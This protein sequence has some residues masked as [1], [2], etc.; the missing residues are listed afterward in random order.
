MRMAVL[1]FVSMFASCALFAQPVLNSEY[2]PKLGLIQTMTEIDP[3][4][5]PA[6]SVG[7]SQ[8]WDFEDIVPLDGAPATTFEYIDPVITPYGESFG[9]ANICNL[10]TDT[11]SYFAYFKVD[12]N[13]WDYLGV[14]T[15]FGPIVFD[16]PMT[17]L[18]PM[19]FGASFK[20][21]AISYL[22]FPDFGYYQFITQQVWYR[23]YGTLKLPQGDFYQVILVESNQKEIDSLAI[24][25]EGYYSIDTIVTTSWAWYKA[26]IT[27]PLGTYSLSSARSKQS[28]AGQE[29][30]Y[31]ESSEEADAQFDLS[32]VSAILEK[33]QPLGADMA[34]YPN[35]ASGDAWLSVEALYNSSAVR[36]AI[37]D[38]TGKA[39]RQESVSL[40]EG[41]NRI[42]LRKGN[43]Q[44]GLYLVSLFLEGQQLSTRLIIE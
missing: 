9:D 41:P 37:F 21:T 40:T 20:D 14:G 7:A 12:E 42:Q 31:W 11:A 6:I 15:D 13:Q 2:F 17:M 43:L 24:P 3:G 29:P 34:V 25:S 23:G 44:P 30:T 18:K 22:E 1:L 10:I 26:G 32:V 35:P 27:N 19:T 4:S 16:D 38:A 8:T 33:A 39:V 36:L 5:L 28:V